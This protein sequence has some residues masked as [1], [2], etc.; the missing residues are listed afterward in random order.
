VLT[1][2]EI[3]PL[4]GLRLTTPRLE[5]RPLA[6]DD[7]PHYVA[8][9]SAGIHDHAPRTPFGKP[10]DESPDLAVNSARWVWQ[11]RARAERDDWVVMLGVWADGALVGA[12]DV[13]ARRFP[14]ERTIET[15]SWLRRDAHGRGYGTEMRLAALLWAFDSLGAEVAET[16][17]F[18]WNAAS[19][20]VSRALGYEPN[21]EGRHSP[22]AG[23]VERELSMRVTADALRRPAWTLGIEGGEAAA[24]FLGLR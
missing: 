8:A 22:R 23:V 19:L 11:Q 20:G 7:I 17:A 5:L 2:E 18:D 14:D 12:Q 4:L 13:V 24:R 10:W 6:D 16:T 21:G 15:G 9:A 1:L 3:W